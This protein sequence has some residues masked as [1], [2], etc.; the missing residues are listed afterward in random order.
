[1]RVLL[2]F[3]LLLVLHSV[4]CELA[5]ITGSLTPTGGIAMK[6]KK[7]NLNFEIELTEDYVLSEF[8]VPKLIIMSPNVFGSKTAKTLEGSIE[9]TGN[10]GFQSTT[11][12]TG[13]DEGENS[14]VTYSHKIP[15]QKGLVLK[16][17]LSNLVYNETARNKE[18]TAFIGL[19]TPDEYILERRVLIP[20]HPFSF[21]AYDEGKITTRFTSSHGFQS[22]ASIVFEYPICMSLPSLA[23]TVSCR[24]IS[25]F[26]AEK[27]IGS[28]VLCKVSGQKLIM[29]Q[30]NRGYPES[31]EQTIR[32]IIEP[33]EQYACGKD[34]Y[35]KITVLVREGGRDMEN[36]V[37]F[38]LNEKPLNETIVAEQEA[39]YN[40]DTTS[41][42]VGLNVSIVLVSVVLA[43]LI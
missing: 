10:N 22:T 37:L 27:G 41:F 36:A 43:L 4:Y 18:M 12:I 15:L 38:G 20:F 1:M 16:L 19:T 32:F 30:I 29:T 21:T 25:W 33:T 14:Y 5:I 13:Y 23:E 26:E 31:K 6:D 24:S 39:N 11:D 34:D 8:F 9:R 3:Q 7:Y 40:A 28:N 35:T 42:G 2:L 17:S